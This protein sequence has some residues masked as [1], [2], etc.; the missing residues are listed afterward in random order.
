[1]A[2]RAT[3]PELILRVQELVSSVLTLLKRKSKLYTLR[4]LDVNVK[5]QQDILWHLLHQLVTS[6]DSIHFD[7]RSKALPPMDVE[8]HM[9][10]QHIT[11]WINQINRVLVELVKSGITIPDIYYKFASNELRLMIFD[12]VAQRA[13]ECDPDKIKEIADT[14]KVTLSEKQQLFAEL[15]H[16]QANI[17]R[18]TRRLTEKNMELEQAQ[19]QLAKCD[20]TKRK[21]AEQVD[22]IHQQYLESN[23]ELDVV[24]HR[25]RE[26]MKF[27][28]EKELQISELTE[29]T[30]TRAHDIELEVQRRIKEQ[31]KEYERAYEQERRSN[32]QLQN[33]IEQE[34]RSIIQLQTQL[35]QD[36][37]SNAQLQTQLEQERRS[38]IQLQTQLEHYQSVSN[39]HERQRIVCQE[40]LAR[41]ETELSDMQQ[42]LTE[43]QASLERYVNAR[44]GG[45]YRAV[46]PIARASTGR[47]P[48]ART[49]GA[50]E[51]PL[52][53]P[54]EFADVEYFTKGKKR[55]SKKK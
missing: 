2:S 28:K 1:M 43:T 46:T 49:P 38:I 8:E 51:T 18:M 22:E 6:L 44:I 54:G 30:R 37:R 25:L 36:R 23:N 9:N 31:T 14:L 33:Q 55:R 13:Q 16:A 5:K 15:E 32:V 35:E 10:M 45:L 20:K 41:K 34:R 29:L 3:V 42:S 39:Q 52:A 7:Y 50:A 12:E 4:E 26:L 11:T 17:N 21:M 53:Q 48:L 40:A 27:T 19:E 24:K 47:T